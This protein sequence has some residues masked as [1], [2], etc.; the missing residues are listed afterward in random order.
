MT[1]CRAWLL[2]SA[3]LIPPV[4][5]WATSAGTYLFGEAQYRRVKLP[6]SELAVP[7]ERE[8]AWSSESRLAETLQASWAARPLPELEQAGRSWTPRLILARLLSGED[9][10]ATNRYLLS[11]RPW[12]KAGSSWWLHKEGNYDFALTVFTTILWRFGEDES[13][14]YPE[15]REHLLQVLLTAEGGRFQRKVPRSLGMV[16]ETENH[17]L[18]T[19]SSRYLK[20][21]WL[22]LRGSRLADHDNQANGLEEELLKLI[23]HLRQTGLYEFNSHPYIAYTLAPLLNLEAFAAPAVQTAARDLLDYLNWSYALG[24]YHLR[25]FAP[26]RRQMAHANLT[27]LTVGYHTALLTAWLSYTE[28][29]FPLP[30]LDRSG[31]PH[32]LF[33]TALPYRPA[34]AVVRLLA[35]KEHP[36]FVRLG[37]GPVSSPEIYSAGR[38]YLLSAGGVHRGRRSLLVAR[39]TTLLLPDG[40]SELAEVF[41]LAGPGTNFRRWNNTGVA[42]RLAVAAGPVHVPARFTQEAA[43]G[44]WRLYSAENGLRI[45]VFSTSDLGLLVLFPETEPSGLLEAVVAANPSPA[46]L[47]RG[48]RF[49]AG[50]EVA[51]DLNGPANR[52]VI[53]AIDGQPVDRRFDRWPLLSGGSSI[54]SAVISAP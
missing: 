16:E 42:D 38:G 12:G 37:H 4:A 35:R 8:M 30:K 39:P 46:D 52:W 48:F 13:R 20:N 27:S 45:A 9:L 28:P 18:M 14:L 49:P 41:H 6:P 7:D 26:F 31:E 15:A 2:G 32:A 53:T 50:S 5:L 33:A 10:E 47:R 40:A 51:Y 54:N 19:E 25:H 34:D 36:Y 24:S 43:H 1:S 11:L 21:R 23:T 29:G 22:Q 3:L 44:H 17:L